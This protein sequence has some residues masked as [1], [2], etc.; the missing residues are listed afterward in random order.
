MNRK[1]FLAPIIVLL[2]L[3]AIAPVMATQPKVWDEKNND[4]FE[5]FQVL[6]RGSFSAS[7]NPNNWQYIP[8]LEECN[9]VIVSW[10]E[11]MTAM[12]IG[13]DGNTYVMGTDFTYE[14]RATYIFY[15]PVFPSPPPV[16]PFT[17][18]SRHFTSQVDYEYTFLPASGIEGTIRMQAIFK[19]G[20]PSSFLGGDYSISS[21]SGTGDLQN[22][23][24]KATTNNT[25]L[26]PHTPS[27]NI[28]H[29]GIVSGWPE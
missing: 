5:T 29:W 15:D 14:G 2:L 20:E 13:V 17:I 25:G 9:K 4:K 19:E 21:L 18:A 28:G 10:D 3:I 6:A 22:V 27:W 26:P 16:I 1:M 8:S 7:L 23:Q 11:V 24:I 12:E